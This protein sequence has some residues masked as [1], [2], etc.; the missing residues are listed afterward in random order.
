MF[1]I[2]YRK[3]RRGAILVNRSKSLKKDIFRSISEIMDKNKLKMNKDERK[4][5]INI[6]LNLMKKIKESN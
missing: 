2:P 3:L 4:S 6:D 5:I 1:K